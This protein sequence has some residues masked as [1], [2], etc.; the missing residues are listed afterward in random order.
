VDLGGNGGC[1]AHELLG[2]LLLDVEFLL[3]AASPFTFFDNSGK[4]Y[5]HL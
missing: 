4:K 3:S 1:N 2:G 5:T